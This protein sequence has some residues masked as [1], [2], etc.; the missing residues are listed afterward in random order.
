MKAINKNE[1]YPL[2]NLNNNNNEIAK[3]LT[4]YDEKNKK[5]KKV[6]KNGRYFF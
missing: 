5:Y 2:K 4:N 3:L 1:N 6:R